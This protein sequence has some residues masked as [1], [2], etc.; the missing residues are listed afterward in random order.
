M[1]S[2]NMSCADNL[3][4]VIGSVVHWQSRLVFTSLT[5]QMMKASLTSSYGLANDKRQ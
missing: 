1:H 4:T 3:Y 2:I 5:P